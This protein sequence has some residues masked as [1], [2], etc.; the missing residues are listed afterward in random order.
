MA[1]FD[2][3]WLVV[4]STPVLAF[5]VG[6][7]AL[8]RPQGVLAEQTAFDRS[9]LSDVVTKTP[10]TPTTPLDVTFGKAVQL[11]GFDGPTTALSRGG[12]FKGVLHFAPQAVLDSDWQVFVHLDAKDGAA[13]R[14]N[15]DHWPVSGRY[16]TGL[17]QVGESIVDRF[18]QTIPVA[19]VAGVYDVWVGL[20]RGDVR[21]PVSGGD[22][23]RVDADNRV[24]VG[25]V[26]IE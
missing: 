1:R 18:E 15:A 5:I 14:I 21:L 2:R 9:T 20:Y 17:W 11:R 26:V 7:L 24:R 25:T 12:R 19:A 13:F 10:S 22:R 8:P 3:R 4:L 6:V 23:S 16:R